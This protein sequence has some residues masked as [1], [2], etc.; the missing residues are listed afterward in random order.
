M[1]VES[2]KLN[3]KGEDRNLKFIE[4]FANLFDSDLNE[5][6]FGYLEVD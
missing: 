1:T 2:Q 5:V 6:R 4:L 3:L